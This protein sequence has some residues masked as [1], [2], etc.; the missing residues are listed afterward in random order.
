MKEGAQD[1]L[2]KGQIEN[3][4]LPRALRHAIE[5]HRMQ[6]EADKVRT[7]QMEFK[8]EFL[9]HVSHELRS[10]LTAIYQFVTILL[11]RLAGEL[12]TEQEEYLKIVLRNVNQ[13]H[14]MI[15]DLL[16]VTGLQAGKLTIELQSTPVGDAIDY[17]VNT[18][19]GAA[20]AKAIILSA[21]IEN[22]LPPAFADPTRVRQ[23]LL[24]LVDNAIKFTPVNG[25]VTVRSRMLDGDRNLLLLEVSDSIIHATPGAQAAKQENLAQDALNFSPSRAGVSERPDEDLS[26]RRT[27]IVRRNTYDEEN[28]FSVR[29]CDLRGAG[30][31][32]RH[33][34]SSP[35]RKRHLQFPRRQRWKRTEGRI[36][37]L[38]SRPLRHRYSRGQRWCGRG[39]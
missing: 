31:A 21:E 35:D 37:V 29:S 11:D 12:N 16:E 20:A 10:P 15:K 27:R 34:P 4:A 38:Q 2:I 17:T 26:G 14:S 13:L 3:R 5:R 30:D 1:Y 24:I 22:G 33:S 39:V 8:D 9:S 7:H 32:G 19:R 18:L 28:W 25:A 36:D 23:I 6:A